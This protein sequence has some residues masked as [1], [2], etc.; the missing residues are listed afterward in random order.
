M[1]YNIT[2]AINCAAG[3][4]SSSAWL[5]LLKTNKVATLATCGTA[6]GRAPSHLTSKAAGL[7]VTCNLTMWRYRLRACHGVDAAWCRA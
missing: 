7:I 1:L 3:S 4:T 5:Q 6:H 2:A